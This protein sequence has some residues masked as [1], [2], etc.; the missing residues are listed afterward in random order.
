MESTNLA[1]L[2]AAHHS[3]GRAQLQA[4]QACINAHLACLAS[5][6]A[7]EATYLAALRCQQ[8]HIHLAIARSQSSTPP[9]NH[10]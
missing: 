1:D 10:D 6:V 5:Q 2:L 4:H 9:E 8:A 3:A 7:L